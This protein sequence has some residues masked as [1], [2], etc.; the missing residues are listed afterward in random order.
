MHRNVVIHLERLPHRLRAAPESQCPVWRL[1][2]NSV[3]GGTNR[4]GAIFR[5][6]NKMLV[7][8]VGDADRPYNNSNSS[9]GKE[10][11]NFVVNGKR[12]NLKGGAF[13]NGK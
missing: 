7:E 2:R 4:G 10:S 12:H 11:P 6:L 3:G 5:T 1:H 8:P 13:Y 9:I